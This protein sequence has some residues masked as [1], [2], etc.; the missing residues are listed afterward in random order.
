MKYTSMLC[1]AVLV[2]TASLC[3]AVGSKVSLKG[4]D[5]KPYTGTITNIQGGKFNVKYN[6]YDFNA[7]LTRDQ[8]VLENDGP[9]APPQQTGNFKVGDRVLCDKAGIDSWEK[10][11]IMPLLKSDFKDG[12]VYRVRLD[13]QARNGMYLEGIIVTPE[14]IK[15]SNEPAYQPEK[16]AKTVGKVT[17]D[18]DN[19]LS[20]DRPIL[21][22]PIQQPRV[23]NGARPNSELLKKLIRC[24][25]G[26]KPASKGYDGAVT[27]DITSLQV[28][29]P[30]KWSY[31]ADDGTGSPGTLVYPVKVTYTENT[32][33]RTQTEV[34]ENWMRI[35]NFYVNAVGEWAISSEESVKMGVR[36]HI[37]RNL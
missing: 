21:D 36:K 7:W 4:V 8:F 14:K 18:A 28:Y 12:T 24:R 30:R 16:T 22:C 35:I 33:Y 20:A 1:L 11:T 9:P 6:G 31:S 25:K 32:F 27:I 10:G 3:Q 23:A 5:G 17:V 29:P 37:P 26:E 13:V 34:S 2:Y 15:P 19:T